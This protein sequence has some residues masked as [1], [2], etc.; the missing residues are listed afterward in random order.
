MVEKDIIETK[1]SEGK[2]KAEEKNWRTQRK[3]WR[4]NQLPQGKI[5]RKKGTDKKYG[6]KNDRR[7]IQRLWWS[8]RRY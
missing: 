3:G 4:K 6:W 7:F 2:E 1:I 8:S 5:K